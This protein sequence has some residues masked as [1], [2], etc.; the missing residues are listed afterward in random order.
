MVHRVC[1]TELTD[2]SSY[3]ASCVGW[4]GLSVAVMVHH[5]CCTELTESTSYG[6]SCVGWNWL[7]DQLLFIVCWMEVIVI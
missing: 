1:W 2:S 4:N 5:M 3:G 7:Q 6:K